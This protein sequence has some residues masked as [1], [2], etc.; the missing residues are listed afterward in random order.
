MKTVTETKLLSPFVAEQF[1]QFVRIEHPS[2]VAFIGA[3]YEWLENNGILR[4]PSQLQKVTDIDT[5]FD[6]FVTQF[7]KQ[8][9]LDFPT[10]LAFNKE[11][12]TPVNVKTLVKNI[13][14][15]YEAKGTEK[16]YELLFRILYDTAVEFYYPKVDLLKASD[17]KWVQKNSLKISS[18]LGKKVFA[19]IGKTV[20][21]YTNGS[22][23]ASATVQNI[24]KYQQGIYDL[25]EVEISG[26]NG[27]F[28]ANSPVIFGDEATETRIYS[29]I[30]AITITSGGSNY[31]VGDRV[32]FTNSGSDSGTGA[33]AEVTQVSSTGEILKIV[34][35]NFGVNY[36]VAP[37][38][39]VSSSKG[40][41]FSGTC[42]VS[43]VNRY[44]GYYANNDGKLS[45]NKV[46]QDNHYYQNYSYVL[47]TEIVVS[48]YRDIIKRLVHPA[49][50]GFFGQISIK[51]CAEANLHT[52]SSLLRY[53]VPIIGHYAP[54]TWSTSDN[55]QKWF[56]SGQTA[57]G[58]DPGKH[59]P[60]IL[61]AEGNPITK[62]YQFVLGT[63]PIYEADFPRA[64]PFWIVYAHPNTRITWPVIAR[65]EYAQKDDFTQWNEWQISSDQRSSWINSFT[66]D[67]RYAWLQYD[68]NTEFRKITIDS[69]FSMPL[70][71][72]LDCRY[73]NG[74]VRDHGSSPNF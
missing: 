26:I 1:P 39:S 10:S 65:I 14:D 60:I 44:A 61:A 72:E 47:K 29:V 66:G 48:R 23:S 36:N 64:D 70:G 56:V 35:K 54:Y 9:L 58:Y 67:S 55:L 13:R 42:T 32:V 69:F 2:V 52:H 71:E 40:Y 31:K 59:D 73:T 34:I 63:S 27:T 57:Q 16:T 68:S 33:E 51:R 11:T 24:T 7:K 49:G 41:G 18:N 15:F 12:G 45:S 8:Y 20:K 21:Q 22:I 19:Y 62:N 38:I 25:T 30:G 74:L 43:A 17:G 50:L 37:S 4:S 5:T 46:L 28:R 6:E 53:E 3:Y